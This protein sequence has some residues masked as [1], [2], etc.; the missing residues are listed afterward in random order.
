MKSGSIPQSS[1]TSIK[2]TIYHNASK[3]HNNDVD[4]RPFFL[5]IKRLPNDTSNTSN[6][7]TPT[8]INETYD[9]PKSFDNVAIMSASVDRNNNQVFLPPQR[10]DKIKNEHRES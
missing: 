4:D 1:P 5:P 8:C 2:A 9:R 6:K 7:K 3:L 10:N